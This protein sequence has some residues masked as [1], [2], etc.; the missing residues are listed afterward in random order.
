MLQPPVKINRVND[1]IVYVQTVGGSILDPA[2]SAIE[3][4]VS[5]S[6]SFFFSYRLIWCCVITIG[7]RYAGEKVRVA[8]QT[9]GPLLQT[10]PILFGDLRFHGPFPRPPERDMVPGRQVPGHRPTLLK[11]PF[12]NPTILYKKKP[13]A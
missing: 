9:A 5:S 10:G 4:N 8:S 6:S 11:T 7:R 1:L 3:V 12:I 13:T 2:R